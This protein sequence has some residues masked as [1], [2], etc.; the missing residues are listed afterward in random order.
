MAAT[1]PTST[2]AIVTALTVLIPLTRDAAAITAQIVKNG[3]LKQ[4]CG[5][6]SM[7]SIL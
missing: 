4:L 2:S 7:A 6:G 1:L 3:N 5:S